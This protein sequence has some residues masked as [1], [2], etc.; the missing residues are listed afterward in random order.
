[1]NTKGGWKF[2]FTFYVTEKIHETL[3]L[4]KGSL[5]Q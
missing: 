1:M 2:K 5:L 4:E 3:H